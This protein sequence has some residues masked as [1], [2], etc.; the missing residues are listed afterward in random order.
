MSPALEDMVKGGE[1]REFDI[2]SLISYFSA[3]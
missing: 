1:I 2:L 3:T